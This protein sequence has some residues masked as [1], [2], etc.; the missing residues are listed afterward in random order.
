MKKAI[1]CAVFLAFLACSTLLFNAQQILA[2]RADTTTPSIDGIFARYVEAIGGQAAVEKITSRVSKGTVEI[3][4]GQEK[5]TVEVYEKAPQKLVQIVKIPGA[6]GWAWGF[7]GSMAWNFV[8]ATGKVEETKGRGLTVAKFEA[9]FYQA[10]KL[11]ERYSHMTL[12][13]VQQ[14][15]YRD[16]PRETYVIQATP[17][18]GGDPEKFYFETQSGLLIR[19][20]TVDNSE[21]GKVLIRE[22]LLDYTTVDGIKVPFTRRLAQ[23]PL[24]FIFRYTDVKQNIVIDDGRFNM[25][26][27]R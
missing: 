20:D 13:G 16:G 17:V 4:G 21:D 18:T 15:Q 6:G 26:S 5:G 14:I 10:L 3:V 23:G 8:P 12:N 19:H 24:I 22:F 27:L 11:K 25:P 1:S 7:N 9:D 2:V